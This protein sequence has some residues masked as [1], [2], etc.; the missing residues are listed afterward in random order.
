MDANQIL[1]TGG[2]SGMTG[3]IIFVLYK[4]LTGKWKIKSTCCGKV[5]GIESNQSEHDLQSMTIP[6]NQTKSNEIV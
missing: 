3:V 5:I 4:L 2:V 6:A 1:A